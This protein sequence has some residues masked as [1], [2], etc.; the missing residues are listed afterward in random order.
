[1][2]LSDAIYPSVPDSRKGVPTFFLKIIEP[3]NGGKWLEKSGIDASWC[4]MGNLRTE[5]SIISSRIDALPCICLIGFE[6]LG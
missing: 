6:F 2:D 5:S 4:G 1:M 3:Q